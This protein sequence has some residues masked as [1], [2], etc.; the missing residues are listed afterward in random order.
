MDI[1]SMALHY[2]LTFHSKLWQMPEPVIKLRFNIQLETKVISEPF[3]PA[4]HKSDTETTKSN[5]TKWNM[6]S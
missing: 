6:Y 3:F 5:A 1:T 2:T 4:N